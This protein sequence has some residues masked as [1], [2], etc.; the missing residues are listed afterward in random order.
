MIPYVQHPTFYDMAESLE[1]QTLVRCRSKLVTG[2][3]LDPANV[4]DELISRRLIP[5]SVGSEMS[6]QT[7]SNDVKARR[8][9]DCVFT[10]IEISS[11]SYQDF[12]DAFT[13]CGWLDDLIGI[14]NATHRKF[15]D[16]I[17][18]CYSAI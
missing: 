2:L 10:K 5:S 18:Y 14:L 4:A 12:I 11:D 17:M 13:E 9:V 3:Q 1:Y 15:F 7:K 16:I 8:L 6:D